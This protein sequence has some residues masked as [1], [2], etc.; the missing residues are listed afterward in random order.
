MSG[1][2]TRVFKGALRKDGPSSSRPGIPSG[3]LNLKL[4]P[5][6]GN[7][8]VQRLI[9]MGTFQAKLAV[10]PPDDPLEREAEEVTNRVMR[11]PA[12][13][14][15]RKCACGASS[16][17]DGECEECRTKRLTETNGAAIIQRRATTT[18][19]NS[20]VAV[21]TVHQ[22]LSGSGRP[23][24]A[25][26][27]TD[28]E[29]RFGRHLGDVRIHTDLQAA[30]SARA[31]NA[32]AYTRG[33]RIVFGSGQYAPGSESGRRLLAHELT[34]VLQQNP[35]AIS[36]LHR[37]PDPNAASND[38][39]SDGIPGPEPP[40]KAPEP[41]DIPIPEPRGESIGELQGI[42]LVE[43]RD[44]MF[45]QLERLAAKN[46]TDAPG[47]FYAAL[48]NEIAGEKEA[49][50]TD[51]SDVDGGA[52]A[53]TE[54][55][56]AMRRV[57]GIVNDVDRE[58][59][60]V[61]DSF[62]AEFEQRARDTALNILAENEKEEKAEAFRFGVLAEKETVPVAD[63][64]AGDCTEEVTRYSM[65]EGSAAVSGLQVAAKILLPRR[66][67]F[68][69]AKDDLEAAR[70]NEMACDYGC[71]SLPDRT[72][73]AEE[74]LKTA[75]TAFQLTLG[76]L[77]GRY[78]ILNAFADPDRNADD[79]EALSKPQDTQT[80]ANRL[81]KE[82]FTRLDNIKTVREKID[83]L[84][85]WQLPVLV[86]LVRAQTG[87]DTDLFFK[88]V[89]DEAVDYN[90]PGWLESIALIVLNIGAIVLAG[91]TGGASL[92]LAA[93]VNAAVAIEHT[94][95]YLLKK[96]LAG[97]AFN[98]AKGLSTDDPSLFWL[99]VEW[100][101][102]GLDVGAAFK[103]VSTAVKTAEV[104]IEAG[105]TAKEAKAISELEALGKNDPKTQEL[106][107]RAIAHLRSGAPEESAILE[108]AGIGE[109]DVEALSEA[110]Q[111]AQK[112]LA[113]G[114]A[115][116]QAIEESVSANAKISRLG[117]IFS[118]SSPCIWMR[119]KY[120]SILGP[121]TL[122]NQP[123]LFRQQFLDLEER[124]AKAAERVNLAEKA[125]KGAELAKA[126][127]AA[128]ALEKE[129]GAFDKQLVR[130]LSYRTGLEK[131]SAAAV[132]Q[133]GRL[134][135]MD[136][137]LVIRLSEVS[138]AAAKRMMGLAPDAL[139]K[140]GSL[141]TEEF[142]KVARLSGHDLEKLAELEQGALAKLAKLNQANLAY[143]ANL[144]P[145][146]IDWLSELPPEALEKIASARV[147]SPFSLR[148][149]AENIGPKTSMSDID[150]MLASAERHRAQLEKA[151]EAI[152]SGDWSKIPDKRSVGRHLGYEI[153]EIAKG[154]GSG[155]Y[156]KEILHY[157][158]INK[159]VLA[160]LEKGR[161]R[162]LITQGRLRGG[163][164]RFDIAVID[165]DKKSVELIDLVPR[166]DPAH[167]A[168]TQ[169]YIKALKK[170]LPKDFSFIGSEMRYVDAEGKV[171]ETLEEATVAK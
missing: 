102:V 99:A 155:G 21:S 10:S 31:V 123:N 29:G 134:A 128:E 142:G 94:K 110:E 78:P 81:G 143:V 47:D 114:T 42:Q 89:A 17:A 75:A 54:H 97:T 145:A 107:S 37:Q 121:E 153:E 93:G 104:A 58:L 61:E 120:A 57:L 137:E 92:V 79:L 170:L 100:I 84:N 62:L 68:D 80:M 72:E 85:I 159:T 103:A 43:D 96:A 39:D 152:D 30:A 171:V 157:R 131:L 146:A 98:R 71:D 83:D 127:K 76:Y 38:D 28:M 90:K 133:S 23:L 52:P 20:G 7:Q 40:P 9:R 35:D 11:A 125:G 117:H 77:G 169:E 36:Q 135:T 65:G 1:A 45:A 67:E 111:L 66:R 148:R 151:F 119:E 3:R 124:A 160:Q 26:V 22:T 46:G 41:A 112:E 69:E 108:A 34:H 27:R 63:C 14:P 73:A 44:F 105:D 33:N 74:R 163:D 139:S 51:P 24:D 156:A 136:R 48:E 50:E 12:P 64:L 132:D 16:S 88:R 8:T 116:G 161:G 19:T 140:F 166:A 91:P 126:K 115:G 87:A 13:A 130:E 122:D 4:P 147:R 70:N 149:M 82:I 18:A 109:K 141:G 56:D 6:L 59:E 49:S 154:I 138:P 5:E 53:P 32:R 158:Q 162:A 2:S 55:L 60:Q 15:R 144:N 164:L 113:Q 86:D 95:D 118:C 129:I 168:K 106:V 167:V 165:F 150:K 25:G 101:G